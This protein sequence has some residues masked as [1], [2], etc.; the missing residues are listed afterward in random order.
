MK[1]AV[2]YESSSGMANGSE[3]PCKKVFLLMKNNHQN[4]KGAQTDASELT[5]QER[6]LFLNAKLTAFWQGEWR[7]R[8]S[9][10]LL[11]G[12]AGGEHASEG[13]L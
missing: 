9:A 4:I 11:P 2:G 3:I 7:G 5:W 13:S 6:A 10:R 8:C 1:A 12:R